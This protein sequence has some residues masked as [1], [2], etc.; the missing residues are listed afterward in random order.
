MNNIQ[1]ACITY[2]AIETKC[3]SHYVTGIKNI[4]KTSGVFTKMFGV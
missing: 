3:T 1:N 4:S 2:F